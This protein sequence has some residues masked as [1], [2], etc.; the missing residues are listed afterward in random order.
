MIFGSFQTS[1]PYEMLTFKKVWAS[2]YPFPIQSG[3]RDILPALVSAECLVLLTVM[4]PAC[5][6]AATFMFSLLYIWPEDNN[7]CFGNGGS[8]HTWHPLCYCQPQCSGSHIRQE[9]SDTQTNLMPHTSMCQPRL[10][11][12][13]GYG[14]T[15][16][17]LAS[18]F[19]P[20]L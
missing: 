4:L 5:H 8:P 13:V 10:A 14:C 7:T 15:P 6:T 11:G 18:F 2:M 20:L 12:F 1:V 9:A 17:A 19:L 3:S 16:G